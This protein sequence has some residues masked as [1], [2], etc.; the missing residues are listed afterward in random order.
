[1]ASFYDNRDEGGPDDAPAPRPPREAVSAFVSKWLRNAGAITSVVLILGVVVW[2]YRLAERD[3]AGLPVLR[4]PDGPARIAPDDPGGDMAQHVGL[5]VNEVAGGKI[6]T[7]APSRVYLAQ[8]PEELTED[9]TAMLGVKSIPQVQRPQPVLLEEASPANE[10][11]ANVPQST[12]IALDDD[13]ASDAEPAA[14]P[15]ARPGEPV[16]VVSKPDQPYQISANAPDDRIPAS[17]P[18]VKSS[19]RPGAR[20]VDVVPPAPAAAA[21]AARPSS[22]KPADKPAAEPPAPAKPAPVVELDPAKVAA[23]TRVVQLGAFDNAEDARTEWDRLTKKFAPQMQGKQRLIQPTTTGDRTY[24][25]LR[26]AG[27]ADLDE[28]RRFC[29]ALVAGKANCIPTLVQ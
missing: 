25:R 13:P 17:V 4:A 21:S 19:P 14:A 22:D 24:Y 8:P 27:Y 16:A 5:A 20:P 9:D 11:T 26:A 10:P 15:P 23:G 29:A 12:A 6:A 18:G 28:A 1:M 2:S 3:M 7:E